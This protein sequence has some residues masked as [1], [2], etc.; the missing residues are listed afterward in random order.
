MHLYYVTKGLQHLYL[1][2]LT[3]CMKYQLSYCV[4]DT[5]KADFRFFRFVKF[6]KR[7]NERL[8]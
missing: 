5:N 2:H 3:D 1:A 6:A 8:G 4:D 7:L